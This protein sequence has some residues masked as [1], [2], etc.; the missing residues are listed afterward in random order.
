MADTRSRRCR[1]S[2]G[3][4]SEWGREHLEAQAESGLT[5]QDYCVANGLPVHTFHSW[6]RRLNLEASDASKG[7]EG[8][9]VHAKWHLWKCVWFHRTLCRPCRWQ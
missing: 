1:R 3:W 4:K 7:K 2:W 8:L 5:I 6:R 9:S